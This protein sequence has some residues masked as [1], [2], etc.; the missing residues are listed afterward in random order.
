MFKSHSCGCWHHYPE[1]GWI[2]FIIMRILYEKPMHGYQLLEEIEERSCGFHKLEPG[3][4]YTLL[5]RMD[6]RGLLE[7]KWEKVEGSPDRRIYKLTEKGVEAL[8][9][10]L[11]SIVKRKMLFDDLA[12]FYHENFEK[13]EKGR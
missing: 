5:R 13:V 10:G 2:Q 1:R 12:K 11:E 4:I 9:M 8:K 6:E 7:S 3:S